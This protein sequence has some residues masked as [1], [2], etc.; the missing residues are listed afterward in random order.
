MEKKIGIADIELD[1]L[2]QAILHQLVKDART[3]ARTLAE[4]LGKSPTTITNRIKKLEESNI[5]SNYG[6]QLNYQKLGFD[7][8]V[9]IEIVVSKGQLVKTE[10]AIAELDYVVA[11]YDVTGTSD[12]IVIGRFQT[13]EQLSQFTK[14]LLA[15]EFVDRTN[16]HIALNT[17]KED[18]NF[19]EQINQ[20]L[21]NQIRQ[22]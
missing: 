19:R 1:A 3:S 20:I 7:W 4:Q 6:A 9:I 12:I 14:Q 10:E 11:V 5:I 2:D 13:R 17:V 8:T 16:S 15:M 21:K 22:K 18:F